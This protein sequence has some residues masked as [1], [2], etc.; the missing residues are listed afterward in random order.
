ML[1][2]CG[3]EPHWVKACKRFLLLLPFALLRDGR[4]SSDPKSPRLPWYGHKWL[5]ASRVV[6][7]CRRHPRRQPCYR[8]PRMARCT[9]V[10]TPSH[11]GSQGPAPKASLTIQAH[12]VVPQDPEPS[13]P[14][15]FLDP[16]RNASLRGDDVD[17]GDDD[18]MTPSA[19]PSD[20]S[21][22]AQQAL[23]AHSDNAARPVAPAHH[24]APHANTPDM[25]TACGQRVARDKHLEPPPPGGNRGHCP[26][27]RHMASST[28]GLTVRRSSSGRNSTQHPPRQ[29]AARCRAGGWGCGRGGPVL[30]ARGGEV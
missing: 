14:H 19:V 25:A 23:V 2:R 21:T 30:L 22:A 26:S 11:G 13:P 6:E 20:P 10:Q 4:V 12:P 7:A 3:P 27:W 8:G 15:P 24:H 1:S 29:G 17:S 9:L 28:V 18:M 16:A 5:H